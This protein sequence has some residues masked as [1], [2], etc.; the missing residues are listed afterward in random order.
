MLLLYFIIYCIQ[1]NYFIIVISSFPNCMQLKK[2]SFF[3]K[4]FNLLLNLRKITSYKQVVC[5]IYILNIY[6]FKFNWVLLLT[7]VYFILKGVVACIWSYISI[8]VKN[9]SIIGFVNHWFWN[10][11][12]GNITVLE[13]FLNIIQNNYIAVHLI[14][15]AFLKEPI[16]WFYLFFDLYIEISNKIL[17]SNFMYIIFK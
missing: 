16:A 12:P 10:L 4:L 17:V 14:L 9:K 2:I 11:K 7:Q 5:V 3:L 15:F 8:L 6:I 1:Q 13:I